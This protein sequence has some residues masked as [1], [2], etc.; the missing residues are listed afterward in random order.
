MHKAAWL[1][2]L[3]LL[4]AGC[5]SS[6]TGVLTLERFFHDPQVRQLADAAAKGS[7]R[8]VAQLVA[9]GVNPNAIGNEGMSPLWWAFAAQNTV[10]MKALM[11]AGADP[12]YVPKGMRDHMLDKA[13]TGSNRSTLKLVQTLLEGGV[14]VNRRDER[15]DTPLTY[16]LFGRPRLEK[17]KLL[18]RYG[19]DVH[20]QDSCGYTLLESALMV[21]AFDVA[22]WLIEQGVDVHH[23]DNNGGSAAWEIDHALKNDLYANWAKK[24]AL[25][26]K[27]ILQT[28]GVHFPPKAPYAWR[29]MRPK[30]WKPCD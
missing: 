16:A 1:L 18:V 24:A 19:G 10:G 29:K 7:A 9:K 26:V 11:Q 3:I 12:D 5:H 8:K 17:I 23:V 4:F 28:K 13:L 2:V 15:G 22:K 6:P 27:A 25:E 14:K 20:T 21:R 30:G